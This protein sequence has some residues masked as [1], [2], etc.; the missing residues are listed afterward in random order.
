MRTGTACALSASTGAALSTEASRGID[1]EA[2]PQEFSIQLATNCDMVY[3]PAYHV[4][5]IPLHM[6]DLGDA[7]RFMHLKKTQV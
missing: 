1:F 3:E 2:N 5:E 4:S 6:S 7:V